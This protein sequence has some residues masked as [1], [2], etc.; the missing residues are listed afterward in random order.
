[1]YAFKT[2]EMIFQRKV[3]ERVEEEEKAREKYTDSSEFQNLRNRLGLSQSTSDARV[4]EELMRL[5]R[6]SQETRTKLGLT[7][8]L[9]QEWGL[10]V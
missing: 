5:W 4:K 3:K 2:K 8:K 6:K 7:K 10:K 9:M 1:M